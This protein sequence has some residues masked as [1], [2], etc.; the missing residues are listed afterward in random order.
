MRVEPE[1]VVDGAAP[2]PPVMEFEED[3]ATKKKKG[4]RRPIYAPV[5]SREAEAP[6][7][8]PIRVHLFVNPFS[9]RRRRGG[10]VAD[11]VTQRLEAAGV[12]VV[13]H[14]ST[15][16]GH[17]LDL[18]AEAEMVDGDAV[19]VVGGDGSVCEVIARAVPKGCLRYAFSDPAVGYRAGDHGTVATVPRP[20]AAAFGHHSLRDG[21]LPSHGI[22]HR[23]GRGCGLSNRGRARPAHRPR[24]SEGRRP[25]RRRGALVLAQPRD[26]GLRSGLDDPRGEDALP[27][28]GAVRAAARICL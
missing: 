19:A 20:T 5:F 13:R 23:V 3:A 21:K 2:P 14:A 12:A 6:G 28:A 7:P 10:R 18:A 25:R 27:R 16:A 26:L 8:P 9:G 11:D 15:H 22:R 24:A 17:F 4:A 1:G